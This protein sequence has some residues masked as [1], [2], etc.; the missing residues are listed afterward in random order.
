MR[1]QFITGLETPGPGLLKTHRT[2]VDDA[3]EWAGFAKFATA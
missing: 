2:P 1:L 3:F